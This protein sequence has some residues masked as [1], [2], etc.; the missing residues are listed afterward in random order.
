MPGLLSRCPQSLLIGAVL[1]SVSSL[2]GAAEAEVSD[3]G[4]LK[5]SRDSGS[6]SCPDESEMLRLVQDVLSA[7]ASDATILVEFRHSQGTYTVSILR[8][9]S[10]GIRVLSDTHSDCTPVAT[11]A[12]TAIALLLETAHEAEEAL[13]APAPVSPEEPTPPPSKPKPTRFGLA[14]RGGASFGTTGVTAGAIDAEVFL[15][16][17]HLQVG[18]GLLHVL[19]QSKDAP[20]GSVTPK[21][22]AATV[23]ACALPFV[24][25]RLI[26]SVCSGASWGFL[27]AQA[28]GYDE[29][30][31]ITRPW[32]AVPLQGA[33]AARLFKTKGAQTWLQ[34]GATGLFPVRKELFVV[35]G[36]GQVLETA[37]VPVLLW[38]GVAVDFGRD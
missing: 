19:N 24:L 10:Q 12:A 35:E 27:S 3:P 21:L 17:R 34:A 36:V 4:F 38:G 20:P 6:Q 32:V 33:L 31:T 26:L 11:A 5:V 22:W 13:P 1:L 23:R 2:G 37:Q 29:N 14:A 25:E 7:P 15:R 16:H 8:E 28:E 18:A 9:G 30:L